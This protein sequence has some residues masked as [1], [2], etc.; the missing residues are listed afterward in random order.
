MHH[1]NRDPERAFSFIK[2]S[3]F[4]VFCLQEVT[5]EFLKR[6]Q[7]L[8]CNIAYGPDLDRLDGNTIERN[9]CVTL[10]PH[11]VLASKDFAFPQF[12]LQ[13]RTRLVVFLLY[14]LGW[15]HITNRRSL[16]ADIELPGFGRTRFFCLHLTLS[17]PGRRARE[18]DTAMTLRDLSIPNIACGDFNIL[19][20]VHITLLSWLLGGRLRDIFAWHRE[21][22][23][24]EARFAELGLRNPLRGRLTQTI[25]RSQLDHIL[26]PSGLR[27]IRADVLP[28]RV[29][30]DHHPVRVEFSR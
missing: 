28:D 24:F 4:D 18:F 21:R 20:S 11:K 12:P 30:S 16:Y 13:W 25:S 26:L 14:P 9:Y 19:E 8:P 7:A 3:G 29:G 6:L 2:D 27:V 5:E 1:R 23:D 17:Y 15:R 22:R 10:T